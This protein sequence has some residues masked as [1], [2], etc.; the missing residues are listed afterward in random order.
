MDE[1]RDVE[2]MRWLGEVKWL[3]WEM[4]GRIRRIKERIEKLRYL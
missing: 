2:T 4:D 3:G 1:E